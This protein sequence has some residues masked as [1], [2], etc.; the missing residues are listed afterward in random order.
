M[1]DF[2][3]CDLLWIDMWT[4][5]KTK[6]KYPHRIVLHPDTLDALLSD[7]YFDY[8]Q[9]IELLTSDYIDIGRWEIKWWAI[10]INNISIIKNIHSKK[11]D[12]F[13]FYVK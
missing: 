10:F 2:T 9:G 4:Y 8:T 5:K 6:G 7:P 1:N 13:V 11:R 3:L 12:R